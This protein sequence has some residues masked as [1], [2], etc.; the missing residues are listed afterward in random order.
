MHGLQTSLLCDVSF[1]PLHVESSVEQTCL[2]LPGSGF[3]FLPL[4]CDVCGVKSKNSA[5][6]WNLEVFSYEFS[7]SFIIVRFTFKSLTH[8]EFLFMDIHL[9]SAMY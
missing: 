9:P 2:T 8:Y 4:T 6:T 3:S 7:K 5:E 1:R